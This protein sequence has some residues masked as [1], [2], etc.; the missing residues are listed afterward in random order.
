M[1]HR[2]KNMDCHETRLFCLGGPTRASVI[3]HRSLITDSLRYFN[4][5]NDK[6]LSKETV[7]TNLEF[8]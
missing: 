3:N 4:Q 5:R 2:Q 6:V 1:H 8:G 7:R